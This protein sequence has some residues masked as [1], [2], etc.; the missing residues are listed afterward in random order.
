MDIFS[1]KR[2]HSETT[3]PNRSPITE[4]RKSSDA[5]EISSHP[6]E[7]S[8]AN[9]SVL[10]SKIAVTDFLGALD[11]AVLIKEEGNTL[12]R[13]G[14]YK[15]AVFKY[16]EAID[17]VSNHVSKQIGLEEYEK[18]KLSIITNLVMCFYKSGD[19]SATQLQCE[20]GFK[21]YPENI[22]LRFYYGLALAKQQNYD[23]AIYALNQALRLD[24][25]NSEISSAIHSLQQEMRSTH[26]EMQGIFSQKEKLKSYKKYWILGGIITTTAFAGL[27]LYKRRRSN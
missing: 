7:K 6:V 8:E 18:F 5:E 4:K 15:E 11:K 23:K 24:P 9:E 21:L 22:K 14:E 17:Y 16:Y 25:S 10:G 12:F 1:F 13:N 2:E 3:S 20:E 19:Y 27:Y 26:Q